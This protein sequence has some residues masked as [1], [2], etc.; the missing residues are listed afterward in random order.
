MKKCFIGLFTLALFLFVMAGQTYA[1][2]NESLFYRPAVLFEEDFEVSDDLDTY[3]HLYTAHANEIGSDG[4]ISGTQSLTTFVV[5]APGQWVDTLSIKKDFTQIKGTNAFEVRAKVKTSNYQ[6]LM[7]EVR[8]NYDGNAVSNMPYEFIVQFDETTKAISRPCWAGWYNA[9]TTLNIFNEEFDM[10]AQGVI[11][12]KFEFSSNEPVIITFRGVIKNLAEVAVMTFDDIV[13]AEKPLATEDFDYIKGNFWEDTIFWANSGG[14]ETDPTKVISGQKSLRYDINSWGLGGITNTKM[15]PPRDTVLRMSFDIRATNGKTFLLATPWSPLYFE[16]N[17][18]FETNTLA[19]PGLSTASAVLDN[20]VLHASMEFT[21][22]SGSADLQSFNFYG[23]KINTELPGS[24]VIDNFKLEVVNKTIN[25]VP[26]YQVGYAI[27]K[28]IGMSYLTNI[29]A[30]EFVALKDD[31]GVVIDP[32]NYTVSDYEF[33]F[34]NSYLDTLEEGMGQV[35]VI[36]TT[37]GNYTLNLDIYDI[38]PAVTPNEVSYTI[39]LKQDLVF[40]VDLTDETLVD[41]KL[42]DVVIPN[43]DVVDGKLV[44]KAATLESLSAGNHTLA[45]HSTG[46]VTY[47][48][49]AVVLGQAPFVTTPYTF[50]KGSATNLSIPHFMDLNIIEG[51]YLGNTKLTEAQFS[52]SET[53]LVLQASYLNSLEPTTHVFTV[54]TMTAGAEFTFSVNI[55]L[56]APTVTSTT[57]NYDVAT[58]DSLDIAMDLRGFPITIVNFKG[59]NITAWT[60]EGGML[61]INQSVLAAET[62]GNKALIVTTAGG[63]I[64]L[65]VVISN[66]ADVNEVIQITVVN[67][68][69]EIQK[70]ASFDPLANVQFSGQ[71]GQT[72]TY[73][74]TFHDTDVPGRYVVTVVVKDAQDN[75]SFVSYIITVLGGEYTV[76]ITYQLTARGGAIDEKT[77]YIDRK[78]YFNL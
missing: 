47:V 53:Q 3:D 75:T 42:N 59:T 41:V 18:N 70:G 74:S 19:H 21:V 39:A 6:Q 51:L 24:Y 60:Y 29:K 48:T 64:T 40:D 72:T 11:T 56:L 5:D 62:L 73:V 67:A 46:G 71:V 26:E 57:V 9:C 35:F 31:Q 54:K 43:L 63:S 76:K 8:K 34:K 32:A 77:L 2:T 16:F 30:S 33:S 4:A 61:S 13:V 27:T 22:P 78:S 66:S 50:N 36:E 52:V 68:N 15:V 44:I 25:V 65:N 69:L 1:K 14:I 28:S 20:G 49:L 12:F 55:P 58:D 23:D 37:V 7:V 17:Y 10:D 45:V 38:R